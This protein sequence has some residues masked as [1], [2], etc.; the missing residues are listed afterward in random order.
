MTAVI[1]GAR[2]G[3]TALI[4]SL[5]RELA[6]Y[7][8]LLHGVVATDALVA[9]ALFGP[10]PRVFCDIAE[11]DGAPAGFAL[12]FYTY[13]TFLARHGIYLEDL[14]VRPEFRGRG[15]GKGLMLNLAKRAVAEGCA[16][17]QWSVLDWNKPSIDFYQSLGARP[18]GDW[19]V[20]RLDGEA[21][22]KAG[23]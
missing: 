18:I 8:R 5:I 2:P 10:N 22:R 15:L 4:H 7:E 21:L 1:R 16:R 20:Y 6:E 19:T 12:W 13:S 9:E 23:S 3:D 11:W 17:M 14:Y